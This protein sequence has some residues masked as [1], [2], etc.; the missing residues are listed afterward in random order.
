MHGGNP[1][2]RAALER[3]PSRRYTTYWTTRRPPSAVA[4]G[5]IAHRRAEE[6]EIGDA[7]TFFEK[8][9]ERTSRPLRSS[10][11]PTPCPSTS[12]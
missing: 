12:R 10:R 3:A 5:L 7:D 4:E 9:K 2:L 8:V 1:A 11:S 6:I